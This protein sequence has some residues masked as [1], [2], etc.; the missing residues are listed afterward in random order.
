[1]RAFVMTATAGLLALCLTP[2]V[3][4]AAKKTCLTG[5]DPS[6]A[7]DLPQITVVRADVDAACPCAS[8]DGSKG[9]THANYVTCASGV[10][11]IQV[12]EGHLRPQ[13]KAT[14]KK[15]YS[16]STC[17]VPASKDE[18]PC[19]KKVTASGKVSCAVKPAAKCVG[20][21]KLTK[22]ACPNATLCIDAADTNGDG[23]I[24][25]GDSGA[26]VV[27]PTATPTSTATPTNTPTPTATFTFTAT[28]TPA[29]RFV[30]NG[31]GTITDNQ[32]GLMWEK[33]DQAGG[34]HDSR[35]G[36]TWAGEC[37]CTTRTAGSPGQCN[38][39]A[40]LCQP[41]PLA[42]S[43]CSGA[44]GGVLGC[45][46]CS[47]GS[48]NVDPFGHGAPTTIWGWLVQLNAS[49]FAGHNNW[50]LPTVGQDG[51]TAQ[52]ET[53]LAAP[54]PCGTNPCVAAVFN[55]GC[56]PACSVTGCSCTAPSGYW[57]ATTYAANPQFAWSVYF[58]G[59]SVA[60]DDKGNGIYVR[61]VR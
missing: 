25:I 20:S 44:T 28:F 15:Y 47:V 34:L 13:C 1:M 33:K 35:T 37:G 3:V 12:G 49:N 54:Y 46:Q 21:G 52:L 61:A 32:T 58:D 53:I 23:I 19:I 31:D 59:G 18:E 16:V 22:P 38:G 10:I 56:A 24:G 51:G 48:C 9:N 27:A 45:S 55:T 43:A 5:T 4:H 60:N 36:Y 2:A 7:H 17:G 11:S 29:P 26:C 8:F 14:V 57:S 40:P 41:N 30:D 50:R 39:S 42:E 6:V